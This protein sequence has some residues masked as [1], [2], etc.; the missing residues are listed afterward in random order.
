MST[1]YLPRQ[2]TATRV[3]PAQT[4]APEVTA[5]V[6]MTNTAPGSATETRMPSRKPQV[7]LIVGITIGGLVV[8]VLIALLVVILYYK[9]SLR[10]QPSP[11]LPSITHVRRN[12]YPLLGRD[13]PVEVPAVE[14]PVELSASTVKQ[15]S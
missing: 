9:K 4:Q 7:G 15:N 10:R 13:V 12:S 5:E 11:P 6:T 8:G 3:Q 1:S 2:N 14:K